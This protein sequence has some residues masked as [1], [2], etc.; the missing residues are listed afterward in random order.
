MDTAQPNP[1]IVQALLQP[2]TDTT[3]PT[4]TIHA[5]DWAVANNQK[6]IITLLHQQGTSMNAINE[7]GYTLLY[8]ASKKNNQAIV[9]Q[10]LALRADPNPKTKR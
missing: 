10:L 9:D 1:A 4:E 3:T 2:N 5:L 7:Q 8:Q 6:E